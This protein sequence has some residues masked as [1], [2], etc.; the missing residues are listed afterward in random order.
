MRLLEQAIKMPP[1]ERVELAQMIL[2]SIDNETDEINKIW[3]DEV[4]NR[5]KLVADGKSKLLDFNELYAQD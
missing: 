5:I 2:A 4:Q 1:K 3:V